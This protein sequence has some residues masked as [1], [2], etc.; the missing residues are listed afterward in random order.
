M[1]K[2]SLFEFRNK[3]GDEKKASKSEGVHGGPSL[4]VYSRGDSLFSSGTR[5]HA[6]RPPLPH[7]APEPEPACFSWREPYPR[8]PSSAHRG[9]KYAC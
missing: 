8:I 7:H 9:V 2:I 3:S 4:G 6:T 1:S 5:G